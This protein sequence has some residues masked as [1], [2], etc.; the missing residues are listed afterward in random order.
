VP[1]F[2]ASLGGRSRRSFRRFSVD[3]RLHAGTT[4]RSGGSG[5]DRASADIRAILDVLE[6][7]EKNRAEAA[8]LLGIR[9]RTLYRKLQQPE[10]AN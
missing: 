5:N 10:P 2:G 7:T 8:R 3:S 9:R 4:A 6:Q 1:L